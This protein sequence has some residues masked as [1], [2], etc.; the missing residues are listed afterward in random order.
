MK[1]TVPVG[2]GPDAAV[3]VA[4][5]VTGW[6]SIDGFADEARVVVVATVTP[7]P[8]TV[9]GIATQLPPPVGHSRTLVVPLEAVA[10]VGVKRWSTVQVPGPV[11]PPPAPQVPKS[12]PNGALIPLPE[13][14]WTW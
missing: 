12:N 5:N 10:A 3:T 7:V 8:D 14:S 2:C 6:P 4:V 1:V 11:K 13:A 9:Y